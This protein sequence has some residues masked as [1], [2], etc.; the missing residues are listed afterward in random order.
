MTGA[1]TLTQ[2]FGSALNLNVHFH[3]LVLDGVYRRDGEG[4]LVFVP[5]PAP[6]TDM[7]KQLADS[8]LSRLG[9]EHARALSDEAL[10]CLRRYDYPGNIRELA[11]ALGISERTLYRKLRRLVSP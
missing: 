5:V 11:A 4:R 3:L 8:L 6:S 2:R 1:V 9:A 10:D 7:L